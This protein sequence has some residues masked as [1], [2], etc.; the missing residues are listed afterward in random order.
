[1]KVEDNLRG[2]DHYCLS[3]QFFFILTIYLSAMILAIVGLAIMFK[4]NYNVFDD[5][6]AIPIILFWLLLLFVFKWICDKF[7]KLFNIWDHNE[8]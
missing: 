3:S 6:A 4:S 5:I 2:A 8:F 1:M 7:V